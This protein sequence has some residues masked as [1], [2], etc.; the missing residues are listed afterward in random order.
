MNLLHGLAWLASIASRR[1]TSVSE[2]DFADMGTA[3]GLDASIGLESQP[4]PALRTKRLINDKSRSRNG[5]LP[6]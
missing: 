1:K 2:P 3:L 5:R 4:E 6:R